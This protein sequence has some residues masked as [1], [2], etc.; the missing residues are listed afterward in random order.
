MI[1]MLDWKELGRLKMMMALFDT[2]RFAKR[3]KDAGVSS[4]HAEAEAEALAEVFAV[5]AQELVTKTEL[6]HEMSQLRSDLIK[7]VTGLAVA[8]ISLMIASLAFFTAQ[9]PA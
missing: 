1:P 5:Q 7:W 6:R 9:L 4:A 3:L 8:Q 2:L